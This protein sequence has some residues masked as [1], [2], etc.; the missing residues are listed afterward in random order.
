[1]AEI[2]INHVK[3]GR[4]E[5]KNEEVMTVLVEHINWAA[6]K[7]KSLHKQH[8]FARITKYSAHVT[9]RSCHVTGLIFSGNFY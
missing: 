4:S 9:L 5:T 8:I 1:M 3:F 2:D 7:G 6:Y